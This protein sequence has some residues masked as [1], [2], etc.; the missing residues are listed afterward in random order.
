MDFSIGKK[1]QGYIDGLLEPAIYKDEN[2]VFQYLNPQFGKTVGVRGHHLDL[3]GSTASDL[4]CGMAAAAEVF[5]EQDRFVMRS[6][7]AVK[8]LNIHPYADGVWGVYIGRKEPVFDENKK[9][10]GVIW[11]GVDITDAYTVAIST[12]LARFGG[13]QNNYELKGDG[14]R[15]S[16]TPRESEVL[17]LILRGKTAKLAA[18]V[19]GVSYRTVQQ[20]IDSLKQKFGVESKIELIDTAMAQGYMSQIPLSIFSKQLSVVLAAE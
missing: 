1:V 17:F 7:R 12:Q 5:E 19:L 14:G 13:L 16:L 3:V 6:G 10:V 8:N 18:A 4:P 2:C 9:A 15:L 20:Y 11:H